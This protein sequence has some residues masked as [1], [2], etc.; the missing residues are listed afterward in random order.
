MG[1][2][3]PRS[4][5]AM[6]VQIVDKKAGHVLALKG[7]HATVHEES[8]E[9]CAGAVPPCADEAAIWRNYRGFEGAC[10][11]PNVTMFEG[12]LQRLIVPEELAKRLERAK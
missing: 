2:T 11:A 1:H 5:R 9:F 8:R 12:N 6:A 10:P 7:N 4:I 3:L